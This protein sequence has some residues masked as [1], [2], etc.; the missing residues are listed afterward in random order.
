MEKD[1][2]HDRL[3]ALGRKI[4]AAEQKLR[5]HA[6]LYHDQAH[7]TS[8][9]LK[10]RYAR[11]QARLDDEAADDEAHGHH[12]TDLERSVRQWLDSFD[13]SHTASN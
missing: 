9:E 10:E 7:L 2:L 5:D 12:V 4:H 13:T 6:H 3:A 8:K 1:P 11:L